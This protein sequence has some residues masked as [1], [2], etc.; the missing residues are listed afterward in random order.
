MRT[1]TLFLR[2][3]SNQ[4][5]DLLVVSFNEADDVQIQGL[6]RCL[7]LFLGPRFVVR[8]ASDNPQFH[9]VV[10]E[11]DEACTDTLLTD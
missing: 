7:T 6:F 3:G 4:I 10:V 11:I 8:Q 9:N 1:R 2:T 5:Q